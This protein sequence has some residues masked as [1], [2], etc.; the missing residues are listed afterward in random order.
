MGSIHCDI[1]LDSFWT[2]KFLKYYS[3]VSVILC[4][5]ISTCCYIK[6]YRS[7]ALSSPSSNSRTR[8]PRTTKRTCA[9][10][11]SAILKKTVSTVLWVQLILVTCFLPAGIVTALVTVQEMTAALFVA[12]TFSLT[13][14]SFLEF[15]S[16]PDLI[17]L[18][19]QGCDTS[20]CSN[21]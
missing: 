21:C 12:W 15:I 1:F 6:I 11:H 20:C 8:S 18:E 14:R 9:I 2:H 10:G 3:F 5:A 7:K 13:L 16:E 17:L 4:V 19:N